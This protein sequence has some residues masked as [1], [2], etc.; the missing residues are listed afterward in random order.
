VN[1]DSDDSDRKERA[2]RSLLASANAL[3]RR[4]GAVLAMLFVPRVYYGYGE[5]YGLI[6][7]A[8]GRSTCPN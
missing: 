5:Y 1:A 2:P 6:F 8:S 4:Y 7:N 3:G